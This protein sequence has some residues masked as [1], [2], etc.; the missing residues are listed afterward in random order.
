[1][2]PSLTPTGNPPAFIPPNNM[3]IGTLGPT[4]YAGQISAHSQKYYDD[5][6]DAAAQNLA[7]PRTALELAAE[8][9]AAAKQKKR[10]PTPALAPC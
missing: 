8:K 6:R 5:I 1:M 10:R 4:F 7:K 9:E 3:G 2:P